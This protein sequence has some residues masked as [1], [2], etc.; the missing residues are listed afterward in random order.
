MTLGSKNA[1]QTSGRF[2]NGGG[3][4]FFWSLQL[5]KK[6]ARAVEET[7]T[8]MER[9]DTGTQSSMFQKYM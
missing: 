2:I 6:G 1:N 4:V 9:L 8:M 7:M 3:F 5:V